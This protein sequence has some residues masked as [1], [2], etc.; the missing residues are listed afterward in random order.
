MGLRGSSV[1]RLL[2]SSACIPLSSTALHAQT[3]PWACEALLWVTPLGHAEDDGTTVPLRLELGHPHWALFILIKYVLQ[4]WLVSWEP[5]L[6]TWA[7]PGVYSLRCPADHLLARSWERRPL[8]RA[9]P[10]LFKSRLAMP[11]P[12]SCSP[13]AQDGMLWVHLQVPGCFNADKKS[14]SAECREPSAGRAPDGRVD[15][16]QPEPRGPARQAELGVGP[17]R[18]SQQ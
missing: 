5:A 13:N 6:M 17:G 9:A 7:C 10:S 1:L 16:G 14:C 2:I 8:A 15:A 12:H 4:N 3:M 18:Q 11:G